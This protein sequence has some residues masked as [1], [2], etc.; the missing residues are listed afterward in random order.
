MMNVT[1]AVPQNQGTQ[2]LRHL[3]AFGT[4]V[5]FSVGLVLGGM[6]QPGKIV[7]FLDFLGEWDPALLGVM[8]GGIMVNMILHPLITK[9]RRAPLFELRFGVPTR[10]DIDLRLLLGAA[11]FGAGWGLGGYCPGPGLATLAT[12]TVPAFIF[13]GFMAAGMHLEKGI[14]ARLFR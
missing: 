3:S 11:I 13:V 2:V 7:G 6:T 14:S 5:L 9:K 1:N 4:G 8:A 12:G 10:R